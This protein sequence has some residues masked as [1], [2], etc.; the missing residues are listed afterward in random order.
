MYKRLLFIIWLVMVLAYL[1]SPLHMTFSYSAYLVLV[2]LYMVA[3]FCFFK[4][5]RKC[6]YFDFDTLFLAFCSIEHLM[7]P[8]YVNTDEFSRLFNT[9]FDT[10]IIFK[11]TLLSAVGLISYM[12]G[13]ASNGEDNNYTI[14]IKRERFS[15]NYNLLLLFIV[16]SI[17]MYYLSGGFEFTRATYIDGPA[18]MQGN[19]LTF[20][21][22][23]LLETFSQ[24]YCTSI[25]LYILKG[26][27]IHTQVK[28]GVV[29]IF[30]FAIA[31]GI[32][33]N[34]TLLSALVLP[35][36]M[37]YFSFVRNLNFQKTVLSGFIG[38][39]AMFA[40]Q[41]VRSGYD[42][43]VD[44]MLF[45]FSD[46]IAPSQTLYAAFE[47]VDKFGFNYGQTMLPP[48]IG[49]IPGLGTA[50]GSWTT[51]GS[52][53]TMTRYLADGV[54]SSGLGTT[55]IVDVYLC[56]GFGGVVLLLYILG[57][58]VHK[59]WK[60]PQTHLIIQTAL[61]ASS[62]FMGRSTYLLPLHGILWGLMF[63]AF[64]NLISAHGNKKNC[65]FS[66]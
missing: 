36:L 13:A 15:F 25:F 7:G 23:V 43:E 42:V 65:F 62:I 14:N 4:A 8:L 60:S 64:L 57:K 21:S 28:M 29:I 3:L 45:L 54:N 51:V 32:A 56:F 31:I 22:A 35:F 30:A 50:L 55:I 34:R 33:G 2:V 41:R 53:E 59:Q 9:S 19:R 46:I 48:I 20:Q 40:I 18:A 16:L 11:A 39:I 26:Y 61:M 47:Y 58:F 63:M 12:L 17:T 37:C 27:R 49:I 6:N 44:S 1:V 10:T 38:V 52:A 24:L 5:K 66:R